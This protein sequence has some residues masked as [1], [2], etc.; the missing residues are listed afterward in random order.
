MK[1]HIFFDGE[2]WLWTVRPSAFVQPTA[3]YV[4][5]QFCRVMNEKRAMQYFTKG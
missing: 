3:W 1:P 2:K 5:T 4:T